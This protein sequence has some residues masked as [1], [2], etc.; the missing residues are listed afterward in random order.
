M[1][2]KKNHEPTQKAVKKYSE[3]ISEVYILKN[4]QINGEKIFLIKISE[5]YFVFNLF[6]V[7]MM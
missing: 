7:F 4:I 1:Y 3:T 6:H 2:F 5:N